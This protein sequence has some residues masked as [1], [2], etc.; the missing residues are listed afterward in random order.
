[1]N[2]NTLPIFTKVPVASSVTVTNTASDRVSGNA[3]ADL[4]TAGEN[5]TRIHQLGAFITANTTVDTALHA[6]IVHEGKVIP[7]ASI[8]LPIYTQPSTTSGMATID[9]LT[10][11]W[12]DANDPAIIMPP[13]SVLR[14]GVATAISAP[15]I[16]TVMG[17]N[18]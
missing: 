16:F 6:F 8:S 11:V 3:A 12:V 2:P 10:A 17:G 18:F 1:M 7:V 13:N 9:M 15:I 14:V 4:L 5:G